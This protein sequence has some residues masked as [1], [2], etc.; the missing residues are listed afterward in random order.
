MTI[1]GYTVYRDDAVATR[2]YVMPSEPRIARD[3]QGLPI[4]SLIVYREDE[5]RISVDDLDEDVGGGI[6][7]FTTELAVD[8]KD[9]RKIERKLR[10]IVYGEDSVD[11]NALDIELDYVTF[12][13]G[14]VQLAIAGEHLRGEDEGE[15]N[16]FLSTIVGD[17]K[18]SGIGA[19]RKAIMA[20]LTQS[21]AALMSQ[22]DRLRTLPINVEYILEFEH[23][24][25]GVK[26]RVWCNMTSAYTLS[27][28]LISYTEKEERY[29]DSDLYHTRTRIK[30]VREEFTRNK[31]CGVEVEPLSSEVDSDTLLAMEKFGF[32]M[33]ER[34]MGKMI[35]ARPTDNNLLEDTW[36]ED[37]VS[38][39]TNNFNFTL[40]RKMVLVRDHI[41]SANIQNVL[42]E[43][44][45]EMITFVD[46]RTDF[47]SFLKV[48]VRVNANFKDL[49][50]DSVTVHL[51]YQRQRVGGGGT[52]E[53]NESFNFTDGATIQTFL[54][55]ANRLSDVKYQYWA[56][57]HYSDSPETFRFSGGTTSQT[58]LVVDVADL[59]LLHVDLGLG[60]VNLKQFPRAK[61][62]LQYHSEELG[63]TLESEIILS[64]AKQTAS[65]TEVIRET[66]GEFR[67]KVDWLR[68]DDDIL[69][70]E[71]RTTKA[72]RLRF[73]APTEDTMEVT[74]VPSGDFKTDV[75]HVLATLRYVDNTDADNPYVVENP[76][77]FTD[78]KQVLSWTVPLRNSEVR[79]FSY[80]YSIVFKDGV[81]ENVPPDPT[82]W[83][84][85]EAG[86]VVVGIKYDVEVDIH[87]FLMTYPDHAKV[88]KVDL[89]IGD[90][91]DSFVFNKDNNTSV[92]WRVRTGSGRKPYWMQVT[93]YSSTGQAIVGPKLDNQT[94]ES[95]VL[96]PIPAPVVEP[97]PT[98]DGG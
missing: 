55:F 43:V 81:V 64:E 31:V 32:D 86:F 2:F 70:G 29:A 66:P 60:L 68:A 5:D 50:I 22:L 48:P 78:S 63:R 3:A 98:P 72:E 39:A 37:Y 35:E 49:P 62:S 6:L 13:T 30:A 57:V 46:L 82:Q 84:P 44:P 80:R 16:E 38:S 53:I 15:N 11:D 56:E 25:V 45:D 1:E 12:T 93:A 69:E 54:T 74:V 59:G 7:T 18:V 4:F 8:D 76:F 83:L 89:G 61:V 90:E 17:G 9:F 77:D 85:G 51:Q 28:E 52:E 34:E 20:K 95:V 91:T 67:Y 58:F 27:R 88:V 36:L 71:W 73:D 10:G 97:A 96:Q 47:F 14:K 23:R 21:G 26:M 24:L 40:D 92:T 87:P 33:L 42:R 75:S 65:W 19:N 41:A 94:S 79:D